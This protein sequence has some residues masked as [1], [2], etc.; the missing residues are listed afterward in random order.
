[1]TA[2]E[3]ISEI[4]KMLED[5]YGVKYRPSVR[6]DLFDY[7]EEMGQDV[8]VALFEFVKR[9]HPTQYREPPCVAIFERIYRKYEDDIELALGNDGAGVK[10]KGLLRPKMTLLPKEVEVEPTPEEKAAAEEAIAKLKKKF[11]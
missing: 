6:N 4:L 5:Y 2:K 3:A 8:S 1:V 7:L 11:L 10:L 9:H